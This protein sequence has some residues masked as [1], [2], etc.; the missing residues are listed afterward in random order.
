MTSNLQGL[1]GELRECPLCDAA[2]IVISPVR[3]GL[4]CGCRSCGCRVNAYNGPTPVR[5]RVIA[6]WNR[7]ESSS[8]VEGGWKL[9]PIEP[10]E[11][12]LNAAVDVD[13]FKLGDISPLGFRISPQMLF[14]RCYG[15]MLAA[16]P[17]PPAGDGTP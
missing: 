5:E 11:E 12:M 13:S 3:D 8:Q 10:T 7:R 2:D 4:V 17:H 9:V 1:A 6:A 16:S 14:E 15:A